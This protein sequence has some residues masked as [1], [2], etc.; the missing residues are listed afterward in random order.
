[1]SSM[2]SV[3]A[4]HCIIRELDSEPKFRRDRSLERVIFDL[5]PEACRGFRCMC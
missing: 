4:G 2:R 5:L 3:K 1:M